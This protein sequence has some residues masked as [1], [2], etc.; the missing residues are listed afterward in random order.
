MTANLFSS[1]QIVVRKICGRFPK[2]SA[3]QQ[4]INLLRA[5]EGKE[6]DDS[7]RCQGEAEVREIR[8]HTHLL[9]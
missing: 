1:P 4:T 6:P 7:N 5:Q 2:V 8:L 9:H 3:K